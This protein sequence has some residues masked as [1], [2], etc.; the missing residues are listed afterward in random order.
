MARKLTWKVALFGALGVGALAYA[1]LRAPRFLYEGR[2]QACEGQGKSCPA[3]YLTR[4]TGSGKLFAPFTGEITKST[5][6]TLILES[7]AE[8]VK[9]VFTF[10]GGSPKALVGP[11]KA[12]MLIAQA[13]FVTVTAF[14]RQGDQDVTLSPSAWLITNA[15]LPAETKTQKWC[16]DRSQLIVPK[17]PD[18]TFAQPTLPRFSLRTLQVTV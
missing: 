13:E 14:R 9:F 7:K 3:L 5:S 17:C 11:V 12:G 15:M 1:A 10:R 8:P 6:D 18:T 16:E 2:V 4:G